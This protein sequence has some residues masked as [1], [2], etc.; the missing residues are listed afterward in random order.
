MNIVSYQKRLYGETDSLG[1][2]DFN[3][4]GKCICFNFGCFY[5]LMAEEFTEVCEMAIGF[6][7]ER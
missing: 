4:F 3:L 5:N 1:I 7:L 6:L 2:T